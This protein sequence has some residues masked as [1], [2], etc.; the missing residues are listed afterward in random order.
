MAER[1]LGD[2]NVGEV[3][4][5]IVEDAATISPGS[6]LDELL[7]KIVEDPRTR[8]VYV[9]DGKN[10]LVGSVRLN[11]V[12]E[13]LF[14][15]TSMSAREDQGI[16]GLVGLIGAKYVKDIMDTHP[17]YVH[18]DTSVND[19]VKLMIEEKV[20]ELPVVDEKQ[21]VIGEI[22]F[23]EIIDAYLKAKKA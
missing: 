2:M 15:M 12:L 11:S 13:Y 19:T 5:L 14:T 1:I 3:H 16:L 8:H 10:T 20:C 9:V 17:S 18:L 6:P 21:R 22:N 7:K 4:K 23:L